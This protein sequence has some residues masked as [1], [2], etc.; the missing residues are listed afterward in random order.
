MPLHTGGALGSQGLLLT[1]ASFQGDL[2]DLGW[3][4]LAVGLYFVWVDNLMS[5]GKFKFRT[6]IGSHFWD[7]L[8][9]VL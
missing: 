2:H 9:E 3:G 5:F 1:Q 7:L 6:T 8:Q 4:K